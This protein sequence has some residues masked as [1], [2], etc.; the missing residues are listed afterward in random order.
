MFTEVRAYTPYVRDGGNAPTDPPS[1]PDE[2]LG[3]PGNLRATSGHTEQVDGR[4]HQTAFTA[5]FTPNTEVIRVESGGEELNIDWTSQREG[6]G[7]EPTFAAITSR[8]YHNGG[9]NATNVDGSTRFVNDNIDIITWRGLATRNGRE[10][11]S[12]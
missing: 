9:V 8:S 5:V 11:V 1:T 10:V 6:R 12:E 3:L 7:E 2:I 4:S